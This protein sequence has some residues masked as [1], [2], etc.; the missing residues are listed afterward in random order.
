MAEY[1]RKST[2]LLMKNQAEGILKHSEAKGSFSIVEDSL[3]VSGNNRQ[4]G[5]TLALTFGADGKPEYDAIVKQ[6]LRKGKIVYS[7]PGDQLEKSF[8]NDELA[9]PS[10]DSVQDT[11]EKTREAL[12]LALSKQNSIAKPA[13]AEPEIFRYTPSQQ[14]QAGIKQRLIRMVEKEVD[15]LEPSRFRHKKLPAAP[16]SPPPPVQHSPPRKLTKED[17]EAWKIPPC[18]SNWKN[19]KGYTIPIDKRVQAD[20]RRFQDVYINDKFAALSE[21]LFLAERTAREEVRLRN[22]AQRALKIQEAQ[23]REEQLR[24]LAAKAREERSKLSRNDEL[25]LA[26]VER[27]RELERELRLEKAGKKIKAAYERDANRDISEKVALGQPNPSKVTDIYDSR[28]LNTSAGLDSGFQA[29]DDESYGIYDKPLFADRSTANIYTHSSERF[30]QSVG[31]SMH[32]P[33]F[34]N[35]NKNAQRTTPVE[36]VKD[37]SDPFGLNSLLD[38]ANKK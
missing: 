9:R 38:K 27:K 29:G 35:A 17:Q 18:V 5:Q 21:S 10:D 12:Q 25:H 2:Q 4:N 23:E 32:V 26:E 37:T 31:D 24:A 6:G 3:A 1:T 20:G 8:T 28:L 7:K 30:N 19:Q 13:S 16:P 11:I 14:S 15:P 33:S 22:E 36:F 34:A